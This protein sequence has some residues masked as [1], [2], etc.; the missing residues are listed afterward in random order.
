MEIRN[1]VKIDGEYVPREKI[2]EEQMK[3]IS[4]NIAIR[5]AAGFGLVPIEEGKEAV[6]K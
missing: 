4:R 1:Y 3:E 5:L 2:S 6:V